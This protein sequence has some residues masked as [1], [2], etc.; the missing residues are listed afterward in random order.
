M[1]LCV[2]VFAADRLLSVERLSQYLA[3]NSVHRGKGASDGTQVGKEDRY[4]DA[5]VEFD[6]CVDGKC[7]SGI[8]QEGN[9]KP[10]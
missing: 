9:G 7:G 4:E 3:E 2:S 6:Y 1:P 8:G 5:G 10:R